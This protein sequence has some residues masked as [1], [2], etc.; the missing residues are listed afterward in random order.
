MG[1]SRV[2]S[3]NNVPHDINVII[4]IPS[5]SAPI[6]YEVDKKSGAMFV[7]RF[8][9]TCMRYPCEYGYIPRTLAEDGDPTDVLVI[10]PIPLTTGSVIRVR[11]IGMLNMT[12]ESGIDKKILAVPVDKLTP[13]YV[14]VQTLDDLPAPLL[15][16]ITHFFTHYKDLDANKWVK[17]DGWCG[18]EEAK[19]EIM[20]SLKRFET[21]EEE[22]T[23]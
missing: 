23:L 12:D 17:V 2:N 14:N 9:S 6:K 20:S 7:D 1:L 16:Q 21:T 5:H 3:G 22:A 11:P 8:L 10:C 19:K 18:P 4:E 15:D 13:L